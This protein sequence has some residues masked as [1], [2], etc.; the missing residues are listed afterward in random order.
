MDLFCLS[1]VALSPFRAGKSS[2]GVFGQISQPL[3]LP[4]VHPCCAAAL[5]ALGGVKEEH[6]SC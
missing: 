3:L 1:Q 6:G 2:G 5:T 4:G